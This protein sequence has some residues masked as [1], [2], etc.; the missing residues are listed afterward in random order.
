ME[1][2]RSALQRQN[3]MMLA[4]VTHEL[5][6]PL[7]VMSGYIDVLLNDSPCPRDRDRLTIMRSAKTMMVTLID[8]ILDAAKLSEGKFRL[9]N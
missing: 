4:G 1:S 9:C 5:K 8:D 6:T 3:K 7:N 2:E